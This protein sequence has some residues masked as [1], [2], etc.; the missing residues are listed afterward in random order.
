MMRQVY[1]AAAERMRQGGMALGDVVQ[2]DASRAVKAFGEERGADVT[3]RQQRHPGQTAVRDVRVA[4]RRGP[5]QP[6]DRGASADRGGVHRP[7]RSQE[8]W[9]GAA[10]ASRG[11]RADLVQRVAT[12]DRTPADVVQR[13]LDVMRKKVKDLGLTNAAQRAQGLGQGGGF[14]AE[15]PRR[16]REG[17]PR[18]DR[19]RRSNIAAAIRDEMFTFDDIAKLDKKSMQKILARSTRGSAGGVAEGGDPGGRAKR[20]SAISANAPPTWCARSATR[21]VRCRCRRC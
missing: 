7:P 19:S 11:A 6:A 20:S 1:A 10:V 13:V 2:P 21:S 12:L 18:E 16:R 15:Q 9:R 17:D 14:A 3:P 8:G 5:R 4:D